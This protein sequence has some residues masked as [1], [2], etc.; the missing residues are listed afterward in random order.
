VDGC[1]PGHKGVL[2]FNRVCKV[3]GQRL[4]NKVVSVLW[5]FNW[6]CHVVKYLSKVVT[7]LLCLWDIVSGCKDI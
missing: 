3:E 1:G 4:E 5:V 7:A 6:S 2:D